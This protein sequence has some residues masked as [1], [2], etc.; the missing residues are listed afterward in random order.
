MKLVYI[1]SPLKGDI[2]GNIEKARGYCRDALLQEACIP[3]APHIYFT[4]FLDDTNEIERQI[5]MKCGI[6]L[7][8]LCDEL[9]VYGKP[10][11]GMK[12]EIKFWNEYVKKPI[13]RK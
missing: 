8:P 12:K 6:E 4:Q 9:W 10:S 2:Q 7:L 13:I 3:I 1:C 5:G 11:E